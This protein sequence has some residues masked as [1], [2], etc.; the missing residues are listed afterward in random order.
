[1]ESTIVMGADRKMADTYIVNVRQTILKE[2][3]AAYQKVGIVEEFSYG[4]DSSSFAIPNLNR[5]W[6][7]AA[8]GRKRGCRNSKRARKE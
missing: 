5:A 3:K 4:E 8:K 2:V 7:Q 1:M 6:G